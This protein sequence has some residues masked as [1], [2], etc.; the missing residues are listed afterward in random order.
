M[1]VRDKNLAK[2]PNYYSD[3]GKLG[4]AAG[5]G[6]QKGFASSHDLAVEAGR[7]AGLRSKMGHKFIKETPKYRYYLKDGKQ[8][9]YRRTDV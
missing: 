1:K 7:K 4:G 6:T 9:R 8:V 2:N 5:V 3:L